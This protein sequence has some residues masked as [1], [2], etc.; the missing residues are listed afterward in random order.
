M[1]DIYFFRHGETDG[2]VARRH[3]PD[4]TRLTPRGKE[5][6]R[7]AGKRAALLHPTHFITSTQVRAVETTRLIGETLT[8]IPET[9]DL[10]QELIRP[11]AINGHYH[12]SFKTIGYLVRWYF[13][14]AGGYGEHGEGESY[15]TFRRRLKEAKQYLATFPPGSR[16][17]VV[18]HSV[19]IT[20]FVAH[21]CSEERLS[22]LR[23]ARFLVKI[24]LLR[25]T[26]MV[27]V[28]FAPEHVNAECPWRIPRQR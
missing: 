12:R 5:Q 14:R 7:A 26:G 21:M 11:D 16:I 23:A 27:H 6:A 9:N 15:Q 19:F 22:L 28:R 10:F 13:D 3:Q 25:N 20:L 24:F 2:N 4:Q 17:V 8:L 1:I 18:S